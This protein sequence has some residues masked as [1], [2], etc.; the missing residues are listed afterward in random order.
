MECTSADLPDV[1][2]RHACCTGKCV[3]G[4]CHVFILPG[5]IIVVVYQNVKVLCAMKYHSR[6]EGCIQYMCI[7]LF[8][9]TL[10]SA[11]QC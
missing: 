4:L 2:P 7:S 3:Y 6:G 11:V 10:T 8:I 9:R 1:P 5:D